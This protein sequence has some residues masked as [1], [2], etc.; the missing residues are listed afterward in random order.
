MHDPFNVFM[1]TGVDSE[2]RLF[3]T[4]PAAGAGD[5]L[6]LRMAVDAVVALSACPGRS[7]G[8]SP[9]GVTVEVLDGSPTG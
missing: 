8:P 5:H 7:S 6:D 9:A 3:F 1:R 2:G 4:P